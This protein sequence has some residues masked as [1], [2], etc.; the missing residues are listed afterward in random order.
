MYIYIYIIYIYCSHRVLSWS[1]PVCTSPTPYSTATFPFQN[2]QRSICKTCKVIY[3]SYRDL[4]AYIYIYIHIYMN[5][6]IS[7]TY[8]AHILF[9]PESRL[10]GRRRRWIR[11]QFACTE[12]RRDLYRYIH[13]CIYIPIYIYTYYSRHILSWSTP[14]WPSPP[15]NSTAIFLCRHSQRSICQ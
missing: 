4:Y 2:L 12:A 10:Y 5:T 8:T 15:L 3:V 14:V 11:L 6:Y 9:C 13:T 7:Y 1:T